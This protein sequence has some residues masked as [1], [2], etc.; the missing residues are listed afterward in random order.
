MKTNWG[1][2]LLSLDC[3]P[4]TIETFF[5]SVP[6][7][8]DILKI[9][10]PARNK[11][12]NIRCGA[13]DIPFGLMGGAIACERVRLMDVVLADHTSRIALKSTMLDRGRNI[14]SGWDLSPD[15]QVSEV[16]GTSVGQYGIFWDG[17]EE[18]VRSVKDVMAIIGDSA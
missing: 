14:I 15:N 4:V 18:T 17:P 10:N 12:N 9:A 16:A 11:I 5:E 6:S 13:G 3:R 1:V 2:K 8:S 7:F